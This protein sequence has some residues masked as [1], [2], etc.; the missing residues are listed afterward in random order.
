[1]S[2]NALFSVS[3]PAVSR[4]PLNGHMEWAEESDG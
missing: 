1:M 2:V 3:V 4:S